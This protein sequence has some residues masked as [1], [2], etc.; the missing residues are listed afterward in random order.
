MA[1]SI[2]FK[3]ENYIDTASIVHNR[4][5]LNTILNNK[6]VDSNGSNYLK[7]QCGILICFGS[8]RISSLS[9]GS[10]ASTTVSLPSVFK[11]TSYSV[12]LQ[13]RIEGAYW[14]WLEETVSNRKTTSFEVKFWNNATEGQTAYGDYDYIAIGNW[15]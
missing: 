2:K 9:S 7:L 1:Q 3:D 4:T 13:R 5:N 6:L 14:S 8:F 12:F 10:G 11:N 15:K